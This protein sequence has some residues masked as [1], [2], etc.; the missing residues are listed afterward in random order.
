MDGWRCDLMIIEDSLIEKMRL[1]V[2][3]EGTS[4][5]GPGG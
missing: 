3:G 4:Q 1:E 5:S 2:E